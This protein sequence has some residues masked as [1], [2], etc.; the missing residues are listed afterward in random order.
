MADNEPK[1]VELYV[2][3]LAPAGTRETQDAIVEQ[4]HALERTGIVDDVDLTVWGNAVCL[5]GA[6]VTLGV[7]SY[8][9]DRVRAFHD[10]CEERRAT[11]DP[12]FTWSAVDSSLTGESYYRVVPPN[13]CL[14]IYVGDRLADV[15]PRTVDGDPQ[16]LE[17]GLRA[18]EREEPRLPELTTS[19][20][21]AR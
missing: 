7:G 6:S 5:D 16:S 20:E 12:Y 13:R 15:Y 3:S 1:R 11:V 9:A 8:I 10:W 14:A 18:L 21:E 4:L 2:R 17:D 19:V